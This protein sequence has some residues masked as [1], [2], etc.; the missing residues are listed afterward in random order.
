MLW[1]KEWDKIS[2]HWLNGQSQE[3]KWW[4]T[5]KPNRHFEFHSR[6]KHLQEKSHCQ[7]TPNLSKMRPFHEPIFNFFHISFNYRKK[8]WNLELKKVSKRVKRPQKMIKYYKWTNPISHSE[9]QAPILNMVCIHNSELV[10]REQV[11][12]WWCFTFIQKGE[13]EIEFAEE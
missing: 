8:F 11:R 13:E 6:R 3:K 12:N 5:P 9:L 1:A 4:M 2:G 7:I 10:P